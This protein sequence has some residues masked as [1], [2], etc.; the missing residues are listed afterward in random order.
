MFR[1]FLT[2]AILLCVLLSISLL[3]TAKT[4]CTT[5]YRYQDNYWDNTYWYPIESQ[6][7][8][9]SQV[10]ITC[11]EFGTKEHVYIWLQ[12]YD[13][14]WVG[15]APVGVAWEDALYPIPFGD[16]IEEEWMPMA[17]DLSEAED[18]EYQLMFWSRGAIDSRVDIQLSSATVTRSTRVYKSGVRVPSSPYD[19]FEFDMPYEEGAILYVPVDIPCRGEI[20]ITL[21]VLGEHVDLFLMQPDTEY[22]SDT[23]MNELGRRGSAYKRS[24]S[25]FVDDPLE[26]QGHTAW[27]IQLYKPDEGGATVTLTIT[28]PDEDDC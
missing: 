18:D 21:E 15:I 9:D 2:G 6:T 7:D 22:A 13:Q 23:T 12:A 27:W 4:Y 1:K 10:T 11:V 25:I 17:L 3:V 28:H 16:L 26:Y 14:M 5:S 24:Y 8:N 20:E 19:H